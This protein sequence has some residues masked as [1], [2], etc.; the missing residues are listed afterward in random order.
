MSEKNP[1]TKKKMKKILLVPRGFEPG[2]SGREAD[3]LPQSYRRFD[4]ETLKTNEFI[5]S[6]S[7]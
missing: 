2:S 3:A 4:V 5:I 1:G 7:N 6:K